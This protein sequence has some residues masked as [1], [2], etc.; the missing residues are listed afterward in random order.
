MSSLDML[1]AEVPRMLVQV[2]PVFDVS[3]VRK[4]SK[5]MTC[6]FLHLWDFSLFGLT[7]KRFRMAF[8]SEV[9]PQQGANFLNKRLVFLPVCVLFQTRMSM[10]YV[11]RIQKAVKRHPNRV[12]RRAS[13][14]GGHWQIRR[15]GRLH[16]CRATHAGWPDTFDTGGNTV[17]HSSFQGRIAFI[18]RKVTVG[19]LLINVRKNCSQDLLK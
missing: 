6:D 18:D 15:Q 16:R 1:M 5:D 14:T 12:L 2:I 13:G 11:W 3:P 7:G 19:K 10:R 17:T 9:Q 4:L 8:P